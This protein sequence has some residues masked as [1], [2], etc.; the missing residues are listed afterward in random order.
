MAVP[1][2]LMVRASSPRRTL[3]SRRCLVGELE[4][5]TLRSGERLAFAFLVVFPLPR[6]AALHRTALGDVVAGQE[7]LDPHGHQ[8][9]R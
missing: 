3:A 5:V 2:R 8:R 7:R 4:A 1:N 6:R 9:G